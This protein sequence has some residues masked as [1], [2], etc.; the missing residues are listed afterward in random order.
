MID[1]FLLHNM[2]I[3]ALVSRIHDYITIDPWVALGVFVLGL[4]LVVITYAKLDFV[5]KIIA[6]YIG[7]DVDPTSDRFRIPIAITFGV[8]LGWLGLEFLE[9]PIATK[10][11]A[12]SI[13]L[14]LLIIVWTRNVIVLGKSAISRI[15]SAR[16][17]DDMVPI[18]GN[19][20][21][22]FA[23]LASVGS[24]LSVWDV[25]ITPLLASAGVLGI[26]AGFAARDT[27]ANF[28]GSISL[29]A[30][31]TYRKGDFIELDEETRGIVWDISIRSTQIQTL[32]GDIVTIPNSKLNNTI[33]R[34]KAQP[35]NSYRFVIPFGVSYRSDP[36][37]VKEIALKIVEEHDKIDSQPEPRIHLR[38]FAESS[39]DFEILCYT[40]H[41]R[42]KI[43]IED[44]VNMKLYN[45]FQEE[46]IE[47]P[48]P[49]RDIHFR[50][51]H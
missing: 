31:E 4:I 48:Y 27:I 49:Q 33:I 28:F 37:K 5:L 23:L 26:V 47:I 20:W 9:L 32:D 43:H 22:I 41:P 45:R 13:L 11:T 14:T 16:Y 46:G 51:D 15:I 50:E 38:E 19:V 29:Y 44:D 8:F 6:D 30:D 34:N 7:L 39:M 1:T 24:V 25:N 40:D 3:G 36:T 35:N 18:L 10:D 17:D 2:N 42:R 21:T 12:T